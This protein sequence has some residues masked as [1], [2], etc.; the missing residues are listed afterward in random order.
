MA[1]K[2]IDL[3]RLVIK[4]FHMTDVEWGEYNN[5][6]TDMRLSCQALF[7]HASYSIFLLFYHGMAP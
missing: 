1:E 4:A 7:S 3:R 5:I 6:T 2:E